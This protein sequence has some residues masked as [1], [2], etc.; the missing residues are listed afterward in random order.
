M[1][2]ERGNQWTPAPSATAQPSSTR[3]DC[4]GCTTGARNH[5]HPTNAR[6]SP[7]TRALT[8]SS[9]PSGRHPDGSERTARTSAETSHAGALAH[10]SYPLITWPDTSEP[11]ANG[12]HQP[13]SSTRSNAEHAASAG[14]PSSSQQSRHP[15]PGAAPNA[16][17]VYTDV[18]DGHA[19]TKHQVTSPSPRSC[20]S[21]SSRAR[22]APTASNQS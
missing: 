10:A 14:P 17:T 22:Y 8:S 7:A 6:Q 15:A 19:N 5:A 20:A 11:R 13:R 18:D 21:T 16:P 1:P 4:A 3:R 9:G 2:T 12:S